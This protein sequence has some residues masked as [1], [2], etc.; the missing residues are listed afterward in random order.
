VFLRV[1]PGPELVGQVYVRVA[2]HCADGGCATHAVH[3]VVTDDGHVGVA[4]QQGIEQ[5][6]S[7]RGFSKCKNSELPA[8]HARKGR[9]GI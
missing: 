7:L 3:V 6:D 4:Q 5:A 8:A 2:A 1:V 9:D